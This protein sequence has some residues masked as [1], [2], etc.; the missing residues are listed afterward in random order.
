VKRHISVILVFILLFSLMAPVARAASD[1]EV[2]TQ[3]SFTAVP[4]A[5]ELVQLYEHYLD[6]TYYNFDY[7][8]LDVRA[9][10]QDTMEQMIL[11]WADHED[12]EVEVVGR[13]TNG[14]PIYLISYGYG[15]T[16]VFLWSQMHGNE[17]SATRALFTLFEFLADNGGEYDELRQTIKENLAL[18]FIPMV[19]P[20]GANIFQRRNANDLDINR[21]AGD[22][23]PGGEFDA[24]PEWDD[25][26]D[27]VEAKILWEVRNRVQ[28]NAK[29]IKFGFNLHDQGEYTA[30]GRGGEKLATL[31]FLAP[32]I[33]GGSG[34]ITGSYEELIEL[35]KVRT[36]NQTRANAMAV[37]TGINEMLQEDAAIPG[38]VGR[39]GDDFGE[40]YFGDSFT[41]AGTSVILIETG[42]YA[43]DEEKLTQRKLNFMA[44]LRGLAEIA[45]GNY[46]SYYEKRPPGENYT[47]TDFKDYFSIP[48]CS[49]SNAYH[50]ELA[51]NGVKIE[52][53]GETAYNMLI[54]RQVS[55]DTQGFIYA[56]DPHNNGYRDIDWYARGHIY[57]VEESSTPSPFGNEKFDASSFTAVQGKEAVVTYVY[58]ENDSPS[59]KTKLLSSSFTAE[60]GKETITEYVYEDDDNITPETKYLYGYNYERISDI[61]LEDALAHLRKGEIVVRV[62]EVPEDIREQ[63]H[64]LPLLI[65]GPNVPADKITGLDLT[66][67]SSSA[68]STPLLTTSPAYFLLKDG[69]GNFKYAVVNGY[70][71]DIERGETVSSNGIYLNMKNF[72]FFGEVPDI[73]MRFWSP[74]AKGGSYGGVTYPDGGRVRSAMQLHKHF[75]IA[76]MMV[77]DTKTLLLDPGDIDNV[78]DTSLVNDGATSVTVESLNEDIA[79]VEL[80][81]CGS[82][83]KNEKEAMPNP[84]R[85]WYALSIKGKAEGITEVEVTWHG[86][87]RD[88]QTD[89]I[90]V[91]VTPTKSNANVLMAINQ[92]HALTIAAGLT[93]ES[94]KK[95]LPKVNLVTLNGNVLADV[96]WDISAYSSDNV[97]QSL[98]ISGSIDLDGLGLQDPKGLAD[99][100]IKIHVK[101]KQVNDLPNA[102]ELE[103]LY[104]HYYLN[105]EDLNV[106]AFR[107]DVIVPLMLKL[108][109]DDDFEIREVGRSTN[110]LPMYLLKYGHGD[111]PV[112]AWSQMHGN[113]ASATRGLFTLFEFLR[114]DD[115]PGGELRETIREKLTLYFL[116][117]VNPDGA[118]IYQR[119]N[120]HDL[121]LNRYAGNTH[122]TDPIE[123]WWRYDKLP[124]PVEAKVLWKVRNEV[125]PDNVPVKFGFNLHDQNEYTAAGRGTGKL[126]IL[127][128]LSPAID[129]GPG[130]VTGSYEELLQKHRRT[131]NQTR[132]NAMSVITG[133]NRMLQE[134]IPE[135][136]GRYGDDFGR[137]YFGDSFTVEGTSVI[138]I[139]SGGSVND[140]EKLL[141]RKLNFMAILRGLIEMAT[142]N[143]ENYYE[144]NER[145]RYNVSDLGEYFH[146]PDCASDPHADLALQ[147]VKIQGK[148]GTYNMLIRRNVTLDGQGYVF[149]NDP[150]A[151]GYRDI[152]WYA[153]GYIYRATE[154]NDVL[155]FGNEKFSADG[156]TVVPG[157]ISDTVY[158][159]MEDVTLQKAIAHLQ[160]GEIA[161]RVQKMPE[162]IRDTIHDLPLVI[163]G[164]NVPAERVTKLHIPSGNGSA[165]TNLLG[166]NPANF[167]LEDSTGKITHAV[168]NGYLVSVTD[169]KPVW[170]PTARPI[171]ELPKLEAGSLKMKNFAY[172][173]EVPDI[174]LRFLQTKENTGLLGPEHKPSEDEGLSYTSM[175]TH[176]HVRIA[177]MRAGESRVLHLDPG[178]VT[179]GDGATSVSVYSRNTNCATVELADCVDKNMRTA[180]PNPERDWK[181]LTITGISP[182]VTEVE[183]HWTGGLRDGQKDII[184]VTV[185]P[186][187]VSHTIVATAGQGGSISPAGNI[188]VIRGENQTFTITANSGYSIADVKVDGKSVGAVNSY[189]FENV[190]THHTISATFKKIVSGRSSK[191]V[192]ASINISTA[193][194]D[195]QSGEDIVV[196]LAPGDHTLT[197]IKNGGK[198]L[199][200]D[201]DYTVVGNTVT[202]KKE[203]LA[204]LTEGQHKLIFEMSGGANPILTIN[205]RD[206]EMSP[207]DWANP[208]TDVDKSGWYYSDVQYVYQ[209]GLF[210]G[211]SPNTFS[212]HIPVTRGMFV[213]V[214]GRLAGED[215]GSYTKSSF[216]DVP[217]SQYYAPFVE[218]AKENGIVTGIGNKLFAPEAEISRQDIAVILYRYAEFV[219]KR[220]MTQSSWSESI[221]FTDAADISDYAIE[222]VLFCSSNNIITG[223]PGNIFDPKTPATRA[224]VAAM[225]RRFITV[226]AE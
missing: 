83:F 204:M 73:H 158:E 71:F 38:Q 102:Q 4:N 125:H 91:T 46:E 12:F 34:N 134:A 213:T 209:N 187:D 189:T 70:L 84:G 160:A 95:L 154:S 136:V 77:G 202:I 131:I 58:K 45:T 216:V 90:T 50:A 180:V 99:A 79:E 86:G 155:L 18:Y 220:A 22:T 30:V 51:L 146:M 93:E 117:M 156:L 138:L 212:P 27:P 106:R 42:G 150:N 166:G 184:T 60:Q 88:G 174:H 20:D 96:D 48:D 100:G 119:R 163:I 153:R 26:P 69:E 208:F 111:I 164:P 128:L 169:G 37:I 137:K 85:D 175:Q 97:D 226:T 21:Y 157:R 144:P 215:L 205:I 173:G 145:G 199:V 66:K 7:S 214:L 135:Q 24:W 107:H 43:N 178:D 142:G 140:E 80:E 44:I 221:P 53:K 191:S 195:K 105:N 133:I 5:E 188:E 118:N 217:V 198:T 64:D 103:S 65:L 122:P 123:F 72:A 29:D 210:L 17:S 67:G 132:A 151:N 101:V 124:D 224:E 223:K 52:G 147:N 98:V 104:Y 68:G 109:E 47:V 39:Y 31:S 225:L 148:E 152:D 129:G 186:S 75:R 185:N 61:T 181:K 35:Q 11:Q 112:F 193:V 171:S 41:L 139:E 92:A 179:N 203:Y 10:R 206:G 8:D 82:E 190:T 87:L 54:R 114:S 9:F 89:I 16:P 162:D 13:S 121:D 161:V 211:T 57:R 28:P 192:S 25:L 207:T 167:F 94:F 200:K 63:I 14:L 81:L 40:R 194:F 159:T 1:W 149:A 172:F 183:V 59:P 55:L 19:N 120:I 115:E 170:D 177:E 141:Q 23:K 110:G 126:A 76:E 15:V 2:Q 74:I 3:N 168:I 36:I 165:G 33:D 182:G 49:T 62:K 113:E 32:A 108:A 130:N 222:G 219:G 197:A 127:S 176:K 201:V 196:S 218:W 116:P 78:G 56:N 143:Y 6:H